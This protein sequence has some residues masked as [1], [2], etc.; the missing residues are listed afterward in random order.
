MAK[1]SAS[2]LSRSRISF[3]NFAIQSIHGCKVDASPAG[4]LYGGLT[5]G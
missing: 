2:A 3:P 5:G 1:I 4:Q